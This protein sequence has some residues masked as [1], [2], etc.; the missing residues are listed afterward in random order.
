MIAD[1]RYWT[2]I[3]KY[4]AHVPDSQIH[5]LF[6]DDFKQDPTRELK[7]CFAFLGVDTDVPTRNVNR[8]LNAASTKHYDT[9]LMHLKMVCT[10]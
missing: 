7:K 10:G 2:L 9:K 5:V 4:R 6:L 3:N 8:K 1:S